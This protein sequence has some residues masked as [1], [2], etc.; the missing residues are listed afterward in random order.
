MVRAPGRA[1]IIGEHIDYCSGTVL[2]FAIDKSMYFCLKKSKKN[3]VEIH[4]FDLNERS[5]YDYSNHHDSNHWNVFFHKLL[6]ILSERYHFEK[7][8]NLCFHSDI[9][10]G[11]GLSSSTAMCCGFLF[12]LNQSFNLKLSNKDIID[13]ASEAEYGLGLFGGLMDQYS[14][15]YGKA[16][17][18][19]ALS[20]LDYSYD[21]LLQ[22]NNSLRFYL[23]N[24]K[25]QHRLIDS[26]YNN[27]RN[28]LGKA[29]TLIEKYRKKILGFHE[30]KISDLEL[31]DE[32]KIKKR[33]RHRITEQKRVEQ[34]IEAIKR[35][36]YKT[37]GHLIRESHVSL[38]DDYEV[39]C[40]EADY[41]VE[42]LDKLT[43]V[44][45][46]RIMGGGFGGHV[47]AIS[48]MSC[49]DK[50]WEFLYEKYKN[51]FGQEIEVI[52]VA[53]SQ[54]LEVYYP[55]ESDIIHNEVPQSGLGGKP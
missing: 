41:I 45:G 1:N 23:I 52:E 10:I 53:P 4:A 16:E 8:F 40:S 5:V 46:S 18:I 42:E 38:K 29:K 25:V 32:G 19:I 37:L 3:H 2:P 21:H 9:P 15:V 28:Q 27:R 47:L 20:C 31:L 12:S 13:I 34:A 11:G 17:N 33:L 6:D 50:I 51:K 49:K 7:A 43:I 26:S 30:L 22:K 48:E 44:L 39:S 54:G 36:D 14:I 35:E 24:T 55:E